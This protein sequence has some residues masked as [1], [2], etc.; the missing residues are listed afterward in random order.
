M[1]GREM[2]SYKIGQALVSVDNVGIFR[3]GKIVARHENGNWII[4]VT[5]PDDH[6]SSLP[7]GRLVSRDEPTVDRYY[8]IKQES[9]RAGHTYR[10]KTS[11]STTY[12]VIETYFAIASDGRE[13][14]QALAWRR[15][16][17]AKELVILYRGDLGRMEEAK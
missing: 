16:G 7:L 13:Y 14:T 12:E 15:E 4:E 10:Y 11:S 3:E 17:D 8:K 9:F 5:V 2:S 6:P 1:S